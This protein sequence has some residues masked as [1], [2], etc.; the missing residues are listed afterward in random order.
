MVHLCLLETNNLD[1]NTFD[2]T[3]RLKQTIKRKTNPNK[4]SHRKL[5]DKPTLISTTLHNH[6]K[7]KTILG[8][9]IR[10]KTDTLETTSKKISKRKR[11]EGISFETK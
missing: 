5:R 4:R 2:N 8:I 10:T 6:I 7:I 9:S 11:N 3:A 1:E